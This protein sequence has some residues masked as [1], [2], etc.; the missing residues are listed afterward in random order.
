MDAA[1]TA[2]LNLT[3]PV[4]QKNLAPAP[5]TF[6]PLREARHTTRSTKTMS[7]TNSATLKLDPKTKTLAGTFL[8]ASRDFKFVLE[9]NGQGAAGTKEPTH[10]AFLVR[11]DG[12]LVESGAAW[13]KTLKDGAHSGATFYSITM[14]DESWAAPLNFAAFPCVDQNNRVVPGEFSVTWRRL[15][16]AA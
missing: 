15:R 16:E 3:L 10:T 1:P 9:P 5:K 11:P 4:T 14:D 8:S 12:Q 13:T 2:T 6:R 7:R